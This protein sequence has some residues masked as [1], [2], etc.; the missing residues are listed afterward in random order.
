M[1]TT[2][3]KGKGLLVAIQQMQVLEGDENRKL[4]K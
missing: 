4:L 2:Y 1:K 3:P